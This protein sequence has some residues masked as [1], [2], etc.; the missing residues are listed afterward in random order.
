MGN[1]GLRNGFEQDYFPRFLSFF[2]GHFFDEK[3]ILFN[4][5]LCS[6]Y[7]EVFRTENIQSRAGRSLKFKFWRQN[8]PDV[9][10]YDIPQL[11]NTD[12]PT[13]V[14]VRIHSPPICWNATS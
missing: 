8:L 4:L 2:F 7:P 13:R 14:E 11:N 3:P 12:P 6:Y 10:L 5:S 9:R 1:P